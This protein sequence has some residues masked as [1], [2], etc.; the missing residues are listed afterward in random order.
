MKR[1]KDYGRFVPEERCFLL[2]NEPPRKWVNLH[3]NKIGDDEIYSEFSNIGDGQTWVRDKD[4]NTVT[5]I[6]YDA[7]YVYIRDEESGEVFSPGGSPSP[8]V[9]E[10]LTCKYFNTRTE[11]QSTYKGIR[12][13]QRAFVPKDYVA[14][15]WTV[16][17]EN[18][19][20]QPR[21]MNVFGYAM[22]QLN[23]CD[24]EGRGVGKT[25]FAVVYPEIG[26]TMVTNR[27]TDCPTDKFKGYMI[28]LN[29][30]KGGNGYRDQFLR[31][32]FAVGTPRILYGW[33]CDNKP[34]YG[35]DCAAVVQTEVEIEPRGVGRVDFII[36]QCSCLN[37]IKAVKASLTEEKIDAMCQEQ[38]DIENVR[39]DQFIIDVGDENYNALM[40]WFVKK[41]VYTYLINKSGFR[42][43]LQADYALSL[44]DYP[45][46]KDN[47][48]RALSSQYPT[49]LVIH[50]FR[51]KNRLTYSDKPAWILMTAPALIKESGDFS[52]LDEV[53]PYFESD[54]LGTV[55]DHMIRT[56]RYLANDTGKHGLCLQHHADWNDGLEA[57]AET[58]ERES[59][60]VTE[61][62]C[63]GLLEMVDL[64][65]R[66]NKLDIAKEA[67]EYY[68]SFAA[69]VNDVAWDGEWYNRFL[70]E[71]G[72]K[73]GSKEAEEGKIF[74]NGNSWAVMSQIAPPDRAVMCMDSLEEW[75]GTPIG[76]KLVS[77][78]FS[79]YDPRIGGMS[80]SMPGSSE[81]GGCYNH[82]AGFKAV[83]DCMLGRAEHAWD[84]WMKVAPDNPA[85]PVSVS[86]N[87]PFSFTN[88]ISQ[89]EYEYGK[90]GYPWR[91]GT[92]AWFT[93]LM[94]EWILG[95]RRHYDGLMI[96]PCLTK[97]VPKASIKR[98]FRGVVY[99][100]TLDNTAGRC[101][102]TTSIKVDGELIEG[103]ILPI[104][105][106]GTTHEVEVI[107]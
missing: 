33:N 102:G 57:T 49:G 8:T 21:K 77:P 32:E 93:I 28:A 51:P 95:A 105:E 42:D 18:L 6:G 29:G 74:I 13:T 82:G 45:A 83:A 7:K 60:M 104:F 96:N 38:E 103:N 30:F 48:L 64:A 76:Y 100:I 85:N 47:F 24:S 101:N 44:S 91:T 65:T 9:V 78:G 53:V 10:D 86:C 87:E 107:I 15:I 98:T 88:S 66:L 19:T 2:E 62:L 80:N 40:N 67:K 4:G 17:L 63:Y 3:T 59:V 25:N 56:M 11:I 50:G 39:A 58:G 81:N 69:R 14:E 55:W 22:F 1:I 75:L 52:L 34:G 89:V 106:A 90:S 41:Q 73:A 79:K 97:R 84:T 61:Q 35:P 72:Y 12:A 70:C 5:L 92:S 43:N 27:N 54:E 94:V 26:G 16:T 46:A 23:G 20:D 68:E 37:D 31:S 36:G 99:N 71:D